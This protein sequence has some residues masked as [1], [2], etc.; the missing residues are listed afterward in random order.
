[1]PVPLD[2][3][4]PNGQVEAVQM[5]VW[6]GT[7]PALW[8]GSTTPGGLVIPRWDTCNVTQTSATVETYVFKLSAV[9]VSTV[10]ITY[11]DSGRTLLLSVV[12]S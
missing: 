2:I 8:T 12:Q 4:F 6:D 11:T 5:Y 10:T 7:K 9:T 1:M 3:F